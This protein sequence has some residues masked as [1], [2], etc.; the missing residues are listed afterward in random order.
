MKI[1]LFWVITLR[2]VV[3]YYRCFGTTYRSHLQGSRIVY[4]WKWVGKSVRNYRYSLRNNPEECTSHLLSR[5][6]LKSFIFWACVCTLCCTACKAHASCV[7][8][9]L[10]PEWLYYIFFPR[11][12]IKGT[13]FEERFFNINCV[14]SFCLQVL[15]ETFLFMKIMQ[16]YVVINIHMFSCKVPVILVRF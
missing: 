8:C 13:I 5:G 14:F 6:S 10:W 7:W 12:L 9:H 16:H 1:V 11:Y 3:I 4:P 15:Y 2:V